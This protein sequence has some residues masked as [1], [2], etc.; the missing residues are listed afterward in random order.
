MDNRTYYQAIV[1]GGFVSALSVVLPLL[2]LINC[3][4]C[5]GVALGGI[6][7]VLYLHKNAHVPSFSMPEVLRIGLATGLAGAFISFFMHYIEFQIYGN[8]QIEWIKNMIENLDE[9]PPLWEDIYED[10]Q[11]PEFHQFAGVSILIRELI[12]FPL[13]TSLGAFLMNQSLI[14]KLNANK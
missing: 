3:L 7:A 14:K 13:F 1:L 4:C 2:N 10:L 5:M 8:W 9:I 11:S 6:T 12:I